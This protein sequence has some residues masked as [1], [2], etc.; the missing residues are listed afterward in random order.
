MAVGHPIP[1]SRPKRLKES[2]RRLEEQLWTE[3]R[4]NEAYEAYRARGV[5]KDGRRFGT[6]SKP[7]TP[8]ATPQGTI[9]TTDMDSRLVKGMRGWIQGYKRAGRDQRTADRDRRRG[10]GRPPDFG[11]LAAEPMVAAQ[12]L[13]TDTS[14]NCP[15]RTLEFQSVS[16]AMSSMVMSMW[17]SWA[18]VRAG[19]RR[20]M[21]A[22]T[23]WTSASI[24]GP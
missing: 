10:D 15:S 17:V 14:Q 18:P 21:I 8:P 11:H 20:S 23:A 22:R 1:R 2:K 12:E 7:Y 9:N 5:M 3:Q 24:A 4:A 13:V 19:T 6:P 16:V